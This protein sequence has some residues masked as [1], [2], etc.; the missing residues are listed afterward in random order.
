MVNAR[1]LFA[2]TL[3]SSSN[4]ILSNVERVSSVFLCVCVV[5]AL[6]FMSTFP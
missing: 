1:D 2:F 5:C 4:M 6:I 3:I